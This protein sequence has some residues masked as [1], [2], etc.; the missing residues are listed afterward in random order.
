MFN[1]YLYWGVPYGLAV[2]LWIFSLQHRK[3]A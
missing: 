1:Q 2:G 3:A